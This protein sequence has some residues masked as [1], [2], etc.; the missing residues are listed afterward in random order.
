MKILLRISITIA[1]A[2]GIVCFLQLYAKYK[3]GRPTGFNRRIVIGV[4]YDA[5]HAALHSSS[6]YIVSLKG[7]RIV[8]AD[9]GKSGMMLSTDFTLKNVDTSWLDLPDSVHFAWGAA[10]IMEKGKQTLLAEGITP[11]IYAFEA[12]DSLRP[13]PVPDGIP[14]FD[15]L[16]P[17]DNGFGFRAIDTTSN[18]Y[19]LGS[20]VPGEKLTVNKSILT[21][22]Q[23]GFFS[24][25]GA[26]LYNSVSR[27]FVYVYYYRNELIGFDQGLDTVYYGSTIDTVTYAKISVHRISSEKKVTF[28][29]PPTRINKHAC[30][31][32]G[33][34]FIYSGR[35]ADNE[36]GRLAFTSSAIDVYSV[37]DFRYLG[38]FYLPNYDGK[39]IRDFAVHGN[40]L[41]ALRGDEVFAF[42]FDRKEFL[43]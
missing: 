18:Q 34:L 14:N 20:F 17:G 27:R 19:I 38:S 15:L 13:T 16:V 7:N 43:R 8:L 35:R 6:L 32:D 4:L 31:S 25:D 2:I 1:T 5:N 41:V 21:P 33:W 30:I 11:N 3:E 29:S 22:Q 9:A 36:K 12:A 40:H 42:A 28:S 24:T 26:L 39:G 37:S 23:D 10:R